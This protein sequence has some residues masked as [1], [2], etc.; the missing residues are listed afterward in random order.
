MILMK[1]AKEI[2]GLIDKG[3]TIP[4]LAVQYRVSE[5]TIKDYD[6]R[7]RKSIE[8]NKNVLIIADLHAPFIREGYLAFCIEMYKK[9]L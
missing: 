8:K 5:T 6:Y 3:I 2:S 1:K 4:V 9:V 7:W